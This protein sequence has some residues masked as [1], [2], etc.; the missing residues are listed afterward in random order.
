MMELILGHNQF[1][2][3]SHISDE[4]SR[5]LDKKFSDVKNIYNLVEKAAE[6]GYSGMV[7]E[8]HPRMLEFME[9]YKKNKTFDMNFYLQLPYA[10]G[11]IQK[12]NEN[13]LF[14][15]IIDIIHRSGPKNLS[16]VVVKNFVNLAKMN[17]YSMALSF[18]KLEIMPFIDFNIKTVLLHNVFTDL[19]L[20]LDLSDCIR[21]YAD[22]ITEEI[23][24]KPGFI[25]ANFHLFQSKL[26]KW[27]IE[28]PLVMTAINPGGYDMHPSK[29]DVENAINRYKGDI[30]AMNILGGGAFSLGVVYNYLLS[31][32][33]IKFCV[34]GTSSE[35]HLKELKNVFQG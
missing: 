3:I 32:D 35:I 29:I 24:L 7:I 2:G 14:G 8:T 13:G 22:F 20:S 11:Y 31:L 6:F 15:L 12:M 9:Y 30:I 26:E 27:D 4:K 19:F 25:T 28:P 18:L 34:V 1:I 23:D 33:K 17:Y 5:E 21:A 16:S 10:Q